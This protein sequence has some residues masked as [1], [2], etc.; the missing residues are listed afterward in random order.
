M[1]NRLPPMDGLRCDWK[2]C[3]AAAQWIPVLDYPRSASGKHSPEIAFIE[4]GLCDRHRAQTTVDH[5][6]AHVS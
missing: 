4:M 2:G 3:P 1:P 5:V 6:L